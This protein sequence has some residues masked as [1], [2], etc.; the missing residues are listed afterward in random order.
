MADAPFPH[1]GSCFVILAPDTAGYLLAVQQMYSFVSSLLTLA[2]NSACKEYGVSS[3]TLARQRKEETE[4]N[5]VAAKS[6][7]KAASKKGKRHIIRL[8][9]VL[10]LACTIPRALSETP[11]QH[12]SRPHVPNTHRGVLT[13]SARWNFCPLDSHQT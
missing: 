10:P 7:T 2:Q 9:F 1:V 13:F 4:N 11:P 8:I 5:S 3:R 6:H 12:A